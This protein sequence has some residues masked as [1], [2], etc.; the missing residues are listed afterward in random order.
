MLLGAG[1]AA[2][3]TIVVACSNQGEGERCEVANGNDDCKTDQ[4][5]I[6]YPAKELG[7]NVESDRCCPADR[8]K[9]THPV[10]KTSI[11]VEGDATAPADTGPPPNEPD[12][13]PDAGA[14]ADAEADA[15]AS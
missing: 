6:C 11:A 8:A 13:E 3:F 15:D 9:A 7:K 4:G 14:D 12:A 5:L 1:L 2:L 10:C